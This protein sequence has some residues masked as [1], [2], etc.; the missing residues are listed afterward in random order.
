MTG[1][2]CETAWVT[3]S[4]VWRSMTSTVQFSAY[5]RIGEEP[6]KVQTSIGT[7]VCWEISMIGVMSAAS[8]RAA[9]FARIFS[10]ELAISWANRVTSLTTWGPAPGNPMSAVSIRNRSMRWRMRIFSSIEGLR[11]EGDWSPSRKVSSSN[12]MGQA[13]LC[14][15]SPLSF[16]SWIS[17]RSSKAVSIRSKGVGE[18]PEH[19]IA[20]AGTEARTMARLPTCA[21]RHGS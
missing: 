17:S 12:W 18:K 13:G 1:S 4:S 21:W 2:P 7:P 14:Q 3:A 11:T 6:M 19:I 16:Q 15:R 20:L 9:Q 5:W 8:V 10:R